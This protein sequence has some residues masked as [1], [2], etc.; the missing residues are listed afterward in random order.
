[1][2]TRT[3]NAVETKERYLLERTVQREIKTEEYLIDIYR[4]REVNRNL[5]TKTISKE[6]N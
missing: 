4:L 1:M 3:Y 5:H 6:D 2:G